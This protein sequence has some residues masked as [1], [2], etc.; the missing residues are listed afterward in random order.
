MAW[1]L[2]PN[3]ARATSSHRANNNTTNGV[4]FLIF[5]DEHLMDGM[6]QAGL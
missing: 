1:Y 5:K 4:A 3:K 2:N 6:K